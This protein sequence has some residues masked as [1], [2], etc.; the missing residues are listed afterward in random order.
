MSEGRGVKGQAPV[1]DLNGA[2]AKEIFEKEA[3][4][5]Q[6]MAEGVAQKV[7]TM[8]HTLM[9]VSPAT[10]PARRLASAAEQ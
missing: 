6:K 7:W 2:R 8:V 3:K 4:E 9:R 5:R 10:L 1:P